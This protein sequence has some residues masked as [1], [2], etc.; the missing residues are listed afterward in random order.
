MQSHKE[1]ADK[2]VLV[3]SSSSDFNHLTGEGESLL[4]IM[5]ERGC[6]SSIMQST[7]RN[8]RPRRFP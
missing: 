4:K 8:P 1:M 3:P 5:K 7:L 2:K 6:T